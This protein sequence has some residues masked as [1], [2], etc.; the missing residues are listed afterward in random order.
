MQRYSKLK[1]CCTANPMNSP[2]QV[3][4]TGGTGGDTR[5]RG[6]RKVALVPQRRELR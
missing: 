6:W 3:A 5:C 1:S 4:V 2:N